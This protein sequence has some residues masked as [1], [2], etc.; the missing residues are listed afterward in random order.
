MEKP[1]IAGG[2][3]VRNT[4]LFYG[5]QYPDEAD[6][7]AVLDVLRS[8]N[9]LTCGPKIGELE[10]KLCR[11]TGAKYA[12]AVSNGTAALHVACLAAGIGEGDEVITTPIT[13][14][15]SANC[16][17]YCGARPVFADID[18]KTWNIDP[19]SVRERITERTKAVV[20]VDFT[21]QSAQLDELLSICHEKG[22]LLITDGAHSIGTKYKGRPTGSIADM[23]T[24]SFHPVK[25]VTA[26]EGGAVTTNDPALYE[27][28]SLYR[29]HGITRNPALMEKQPDGPWY[30]EQVALGYNYRMT[31]IQAAL[32]ISQLDKLD[33]FIQRR[34]EI[35]ARYNEAFRK[36]PQLIVQEE[37]PESDTARHLYI[38]RIRT[39]SLTIDRKGFFDALDAENI[40]CNVH[41]IPVYYFPWYQKLGYRKG[42]CPKAEKLYEGILTLPLHYNLTDGDVDDVIRAVEKIAAYYAK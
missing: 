31:D 8:G 34:K 19:A 20:A 37:I 7:Q 39:G 27:K 35:V 21:G 23:T 9:D 2:T 16:A 1:A 4:K 40:R 18:E 24:F 26:G 3:P 6:Y 15:A 12:V 13:F 10:E 30:Y 41:Y 28:L 25:T 32:L 29:A 38:I 42:L 17:L 33:R 14:A 11:V 36:I 5:H 22:I